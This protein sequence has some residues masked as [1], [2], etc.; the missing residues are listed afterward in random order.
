MRNYKNTPKLWD[1]YANATYHKIRYAAVS[2]D[3]K[4]L[5][6]AFLTYGSKLDLS[7]F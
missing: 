6:C 2:G 1:N 3:K 7:L 5:E 4:I